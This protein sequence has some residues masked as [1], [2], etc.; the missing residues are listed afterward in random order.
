MGYHFSPTRMAII[1][2]RKTVSNISEAIEKLETSYI[3]GGNIKWRSHFGN[4]LGIFSDKW[5][6]AL[7][8]DGAY[9]LLGIYPAAMKT[10]PHEDPRTS[11]HSNIT[12]NG[13]KQETSQMHIRWWLD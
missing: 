8:S 6:T 13:S 3:A 4:Q 2:K 11:V 7:P 1:L 10:C 12:H 5:S 9:L